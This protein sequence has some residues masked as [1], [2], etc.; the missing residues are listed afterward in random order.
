MCWSAVQMHIALLDTYAPMQLAGL[1]SS[2]ENRGMPL[3]DG[4]KQ[5]M[6]LNWLAPAGSE[7]ETRVVDYVVQHHRLKAPER[8]LLLKWKNQ[9]DKLG[10]HN[11]AFWAIVKKL[12]LSPQTYDQAMERHRMLSD[13]GWFVAYYIAHRKSNKEIEQ[14]L[15]LSRRGVDYHLREIRSLIR[16]NTWQV[17][18]R[19]ALGRWFVGLD[20]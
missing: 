15:G 19:A 16:R 3:T 18:S 8:K 14:A 1:Q 12:K 11:H 17:V 2:A 5:Q 20:Y 9:N 4:E 7:E 6:R 10:M 13:N